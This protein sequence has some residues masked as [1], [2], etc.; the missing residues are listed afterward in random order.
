MNNSSINKIKIDLARS[1]DSYIYDLNTNRKYLDFMGMYSTLSIGYNN[2][3]LIKSF[4]GSDVMENLLVNKITNCE[5]NSDIL[6]EFEETFKLEMSL[7]EFSN[8][9][10][11]SS[12]ALA[13]EAAVKTAI[14]SCEKENPIILTFNGSFHG[15]Y[16]YGGILT[17]RFDS[18][19]SRLEGFP[20]NYWEKLKPFY[21]KGSNFLN[22]ESLEQ[23][24]NSLE[25]Y[26]KNFKDRIA[27]V[28][29]EPVQCTFGD[30]YLDLQ[31][32]N[33]LK[34][35]SNTLNVPLIFDE[36]QTGFYSS[37]K[38]WYYNHTEV[39]P[40]ILVFGK[41]AQ[42]SGIMVNERHSNI[43]KAPSTLEATWDSNLID[44]FRSLSILKILNK[45]HN[46]S[47]QIIKNSNYFIDK[48]KNHS[49]IKNIRHLGYL[50]AFDF[51][52]KEF[53]NDFVELIKENGLL[54]NPTRL[55]TVRFRPHL[56]SEIS[57]FKNALSI[58]NKSLD[59][60][61]NK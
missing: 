42:L 26:V 57:D 51:E 44:M 50:I 36:I 19:K 48:L 56:L 14:K 31:Y 23:S 13:I 21:D 32:L 39:V 33:K 25:L 49:E 2:E 28:L 8:F 29:V 5:I 35:I 30:H 59:E 3:E 24:I 45:K 15:I 10:F 4:R 22:S 53:R 18:V 60:L 7:N 54:C 9:Y 38:K 43:F 37:G 52:T 46:L 34:N 47:D 12:G 41:K 61:K 16:G 11:T 55:K 17:D 27:G 40:D 6:L 20:G 1:K 58:I